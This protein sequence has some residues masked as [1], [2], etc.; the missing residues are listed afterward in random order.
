MFIYSITMNN[1]INTKDIE[2][3][4]FY[5]YNNVTNFMDND[6]KEFYPINFTD[7]HNNQCQNN[8][9]NTT[10]FDIRQNINT[11]NTTQFDIRQNI[12][13]NTRLSDDFEL[14]SFDKYHLNNIQ[15]NNISDIDI[16]EI[17][18]ETKD[19][20]NQHINNR[21][22]QSSNLSQ[23]NR[24]NRDNMQCSNGICRPV[25]SK[26]IKQNNSNLQK[27]YNHSNNYKYDIQGRIKKN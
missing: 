18:D 9:Y 14:P 16:K 24:F 26:N 5:N 10:Q 22:N 13:T 3:A 2:K 15:N 21:F 7:S 11:N 23:F 8:K 6:I 12:N 20:L 1:N 25:S 17:D 19:H 27:Q 4:K